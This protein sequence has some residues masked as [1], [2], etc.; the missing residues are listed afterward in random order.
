M[1]HIVSQ[2]RH[3]EVKSNVAVLSVKTA[4]MDIFVYTTADGPKNIKKSASTPFLIDLHCEKHSKR[5]RIR[6]KWVRIAH[7]VKLWHNFEQNLNVA[8]LRVKTATL[9]VKNECFLAIFAQSLLQNSEK[10][11]F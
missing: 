6:V 4:T 1:A 2:K 5:F 3:F 9:G 11:L 8:V 7:R 10:T